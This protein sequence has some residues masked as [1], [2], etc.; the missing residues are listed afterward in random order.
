MRVLK[1]RAAAV[2]VA[3]A[4]T[5]AGMAAHGEPRLLPVRT[6]GVIEL[7]PGSAGARLS[8]IDPV[9]VE[10][11]IVPGLAATEPWRSADVPAWVQ[12][13]PY[14]DAVAIGGGSLYDGVDRLWAGFVPSSDGE[15]VGRRFAVP[16]RG[17]ILAFVRADADLSGPIVTVTARGSTEPA[18]ELYADGTWAASGRYLV[19]LV[20]EIGAA[21]ADLALANDGFV[22]LVGDLSRRSRWTFNP[23]SVDPGE[24][25]VGLVSGAVF[26]AQT[27]IVVRALEDGTHLELVDLTDGDDTLSVDLGAGE[28]FVTSWPGDAVAAGRLSVAATAID[29]DVIELR[30]DRPVLVH[31]GAF[32]P[33][34][35]AGVFPSAPTGPAQH[36]AMFST[37]P[38]LVHFAA[39]AATPITVRPLAAHGAL[40]GPWSVTEPMWQGDG[41]AFATAP[42]E[43]AE[44]LWLAEA[45]AP[46]VVTT[47]PLDGLVP[48]IALPLDVGPALAPVAVA[49]A[50]A[51]VCPAEPITLDG[52]RSFD[53]DGLG[54]GDPVVAWSWDV[55]IARDSDTTGGPDDDVD[56]AAPALTWRYVTAGRKTAR[57]RVTDNDGQTDLDDLIIEVRVPADPICGGD[58]DGDA[59]GSAQDNCPETPNTDQL[60]RDN[61]G[62][63]DACDSDL[64][65]DGVNNAV[66]ACPRTPDPD[67]TDTDG[68]GLGDACDD[69]WDNDSLDNAFD[70]CPLVFNRD[71]ADLDRDGAGDQ[72]D[73]DRDGDGLPDLLDN[74]PGLPNPD[75]ADLDGDRFGDLCD[76]DDD[77]DLVPDDADN[78]PALPNPDQA[79]RNRNGAGDA[80]ELDSDGDE[81]PDAIDNCPTLPNPD[82]ADLDSDGT[83]DRCDED[84]DGDFIRNG[85]DNCPLVF[86]PDQVDVDRNGLGDV[87]EPD[88]DGDGLPDY[89]DNCPRVP[90]A[91]QH[92]LD[93][94]S[95]GDA[96]DDDADGDNLRDDQEASHGTRADDPDTDNDGLSDGLEL[97]LGT[98]PTLWDTD[99]DNISDGAEFAARTDPLNVDTDGDGVS[100]GAEDG[101]DEDSDLDG[102]INA[103][104]TDSD[105]GGVADGEEIRT[106][107]NMLDPTD[108]VPA[109]TGRVAGGE[110]CASISAGRGLTP[111][112]TPTYLLLM[113]ALGALARAGHRTAGRKRDRE[114]HR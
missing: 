17:A 56:S 50:W 24:R 35:A 110:G 73:P 77:G 44:A 64:D 25:S 39:E 14:R 52:T 107:R 7:V 72:C 33:S 114:P 84:R 54:E 38:G 30:A 87:C 29:R 18:V 83:G 34:Q 22:Q 68:D 65:G 94:D 4:L 89:A 2:A 108:D 92:N 106:G 42:L 103:R 13:A 90:N 76:G 10:P 82:Q 112:P 113:V 15:L 11:T 101:W 79:D 49:G 19:F 27:S 104:D 37:G 96:C 20:P 61:D 80:C 63:G 62:L 66:D 31:A 51:Q 21:I 59:I 8:V 1:A 46:F 45:G 5:A 28:L 88:R 93:R 78:C 102:A 32:E 48:T 41:F 69:D 98:N 16:A 57:L 12:I 81:I 43:G 85:S 97:V 91:D 6:S 109:V 71:Q 105:N 47:E 36:T 26:A 74:C 75:Q 55:D 100:D 95:F 53:A 58:V 60:D 111:Y 99:G 9:G 3:M 86:N 70:N 67:Q 23:P 40:P